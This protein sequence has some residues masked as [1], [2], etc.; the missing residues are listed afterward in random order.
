MKKIIYSLFILF[1]MSSCG[2]NSTEGQLKEASDEAT[3]EEYSNEE[4]NYNVDS[5]RADDAQVPTDG[6]EFEQDSL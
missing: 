5:L 2:E 4:D 3:T 6:T 1:L